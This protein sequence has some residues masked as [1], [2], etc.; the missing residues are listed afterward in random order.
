MRILHCV[1]QYHPSVGG[2][3]E[4]VRRLSE[5]LAAAGHDVTVATKSHPQRSW[6]TLNGVAVQGFD[7]TGNLA[8][9]LH[10]D[11]AGYREFVRAGRFDV[12]TLFA[13]QQALCDALLTILDELPTQRVFVPT[14]FSALYRADYQDYFQR[15]RDWMGSF[16]ANV[17]L[18]HSYRDAVFARE[19]G[20]PNRVLIPN[21]AAAS[22]FVRPSDLDI[23]AQLGIAADSFL[24]LLVGSHTGLKG[25]RE[26]VEAFARAEL[27]AATLLIVGNY[28]DQPPSGVLTVLKRLAGRLLGR[29]PQH[30]PAWCR[31]A[32]DRF[33]RSGKRKQDGKRLLIH[34]LSREETV[35]AY[36]TADLF[37]FPS[38]VECS[39]IVLYEA[40]AS[41]TPFL[42]SPAGNAE[43]IA[44]WSGAGRILKAAVDREGYCT[45]D[46]GDAVLMLEAIYRDAATRT[47]MAERGFHSWR[48]HFTWEG[49]AAAYER[50]YRLL[51]EQ[52]NPDVTNSQE[53]IWSIPNNG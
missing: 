52:Q 8:T 51:Q 3:Q 4:V 53:E 42:S 13:A 33:N 27:P 18:S 32:A 5:L 44:A 16:H 39:P 15:M 12:I 48:R 23:R 20:V 36:R 24:I 45:I 11:V 26:A 14:G 47:R 31:I 43:E 49:I 6:N 41:R 29:E 35:A 19:G 10:G 17:F 37:F 1:E 2:M 46:E 34:S 22:E 40:M 30:C 28:C 50:L 9:G 21:G 38:R 7:L 25:H